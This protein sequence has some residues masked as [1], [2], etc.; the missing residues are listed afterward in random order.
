MFSNRPN[1]PEA[2]AAVTTNQGPMPL[3]LGEGVIT[4]ISEETNPRL[5]K[6]KELQQIQ[7][8]IC[9]TIRPTW[10][11]G[12]PKIFGEK[13]HGKLKADQWRSCLE[14]DLPVSIAYLLQDAQAK[15]DLDDISRLEKVLSS[16]MH[17]ALAT[18]WATSRRMSH[19]H[20]SSYLEFMLAYLKSIRTLRP[21]LNLLP[22]HHNALH[23]PEFLLLFGP[24]HSWWMFVFERVNGMLQTTPSNSRIGELG[25]TS[26]LVEFA[27]PFGLTGQLEKTFLDSFC[28]AG[29]IKA[30]TKR[31]CT[32]SAL[33][34][35]S[36]ILSESL[37]N[38]TRGTLLSDIAC[39]LPNPSP[40]SPSFETKVSELSGI[41][42]DAIMAA[43]GSLQQELPGWV[44]STSASTHTRYDINGLTFTCYKTNQRNGVVL[45]QT[46][47]NGELRPGAIRD[48]FTT[49]NLDGSS[50]WTFLA[51]HPC[52]PSTEGDGVFSRWP[53]WGVSIWSNEFNTALVDLVP[54]SRRICHTIRRKWKENCQALKGLSRVWLFFVNQSF[55]VPNP[56]SGT[57]NGVTSR[58]RIVNITLV[59]LSM[60]PYEQLLVS[61]SLNEMS[62][63]I[64]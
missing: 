24:M 39:F 58:E 54:T 35:C 14:F 38:D 26:L 42:V 10:H 8:D 9:I 56:L 20:A 16:T 15:N 27:R 57:M 45:Y 30:F 47:P 49:Y 41:V 28:A 52:F 5:L 18:E 22:N 61:L 50:S 12:P 34:E 64:D 25:I 40:T 36:E 4:L 13:G 6:P 11:E 43:A 29:R 59:T 19:E 44:P 55:N 32:N 1:R 23:I 17:L 53:D 21:D 3:I 51:I 63:C 37:P 7:Q 2:P 60:S 46:S 31:V 62:G 48:I 33:R